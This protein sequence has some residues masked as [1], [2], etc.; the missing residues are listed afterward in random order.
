MRT[1]VVALTFASL[2]SPALSQME[3]GAEIMRQVQDFNRHTE[4][5]L[6]EYRQSGDYARYKR[7]IE[8]LLDIEL[9]GIV[10]Q[11]GESEVVQRNKRLW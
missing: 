7:Q 9:Q 6:A 1:L 3:G 11:I 5:A 4:R 10:R 8:P 2:A